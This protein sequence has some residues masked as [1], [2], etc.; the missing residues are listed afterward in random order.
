MILSGKVGVELMQ[1]AQVSN[2]PN[3]KFEARLHKYLAFLH[4]HF[5]KVSWKRVPYAIKIRQF[6]CHVR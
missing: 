6:L 2:N 1:E 5:E 3:A 4:A